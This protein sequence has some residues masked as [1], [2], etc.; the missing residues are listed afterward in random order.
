MRLAAHFRTCVSAFALAVLVQGA[1]TRDYPAK[2][3]LPDVKT[4]AE[5]GYPGFETSHKAD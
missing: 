1:H 5:Q 4:V 2:P 3:I